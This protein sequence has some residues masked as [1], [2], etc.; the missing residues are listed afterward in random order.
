MS[1]LLYLQRQK[2]MNETKN[3]IQEWLIN[4]KNWSDLNGCKL[5]T[6]SST[7]TPAGI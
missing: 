3:I 2:G 1:E 7:L 4:F 6:E 5:D